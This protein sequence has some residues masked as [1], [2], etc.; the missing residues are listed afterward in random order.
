M[1]NTNLKLIY[2]V[3]ENSVQ[4]CNVSKKNIRWISKACYTSSGIRQGC[5]ISAIF[6]LFVADILALKIKKEMTEW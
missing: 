5:P 1:K 3:D 2:K 6:Y 4:Y